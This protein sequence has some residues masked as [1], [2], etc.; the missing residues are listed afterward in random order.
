MTHDKFSYYYL[1]TKKEMIIS[2]A[3]VR[4]DVVVRPRDDNQISDG[5]GL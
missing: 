3:T 4:E 2:G 5:L 1:I